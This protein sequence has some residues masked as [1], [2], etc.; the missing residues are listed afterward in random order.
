MDDLSAFALRFISGKYQGGE[1]PLP[2]GREVVVGREGELDL[3]LVEDMVSRRHAKLWVANQQLTI[4]D[5]GSTNGTFVNGKKVEKA[6]LQTGD[7][8]LIGTNI[9]KLIAASESSLPSE[10]GKMDRSEVQAMLEGLAE[11]RKDMPLTLSG[12]LSD[13]PVP[14]L[15]QMYSNTKQSGTLSIGTDED[16]ARVYFRDGRIYYAILNNNDELGPLKALYRVFLWDRGEFRFGPLQD[17]DFLLELEES[18]SQLILEGVRQAD[19]LRSVLQHLPEMEEMVSPSKPLQPALADLRPDEL[20]VFQLAYN[21]SFLQSIFD[22]SPLTDLKTAEALQRLLR[23][24]YLE[25]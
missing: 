14:D 5:L 20:E 13:M 16:S 7:R 8:I 25:S 1:F 6:T 21:L 15:L 22:A 3:V 18:T 4:Q 9:L 12:S 23:E 24:G 2:E 11:Q 10:G 17:D 19:T